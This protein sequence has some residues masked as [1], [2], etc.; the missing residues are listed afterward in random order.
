M[1]NRA[2]LASTLAVLFLALP[3]STILPNSTALDVPPP[4]LY[5]TLVATEVGAN[6]RFTPQDAQSQTI[7]VVPQVPVVLNIT[8]IF[9]DVLDHSFTIRSTD[10]AAASAY[11][12]NVDL[13]V[14]MG[15]GNSKTVEFLIVEEDRIVF[16]GRNETVET[17]GSGIRFFCVPH[18]AADMEGFIA[19]G[20]VTA[21]T[22]PP[23]KGVFLRAYWIGLLGFAGTLLLVGTSYFVIKGSSRHYRDHHEHI[24]RGGP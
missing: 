6:P 9:D 24:R 8:L 19:I 7:I 23:E 2:V 11:L 16:E 10:P 1:R 18:E 3:L 20:G 21:T 15:R 4:R 17:G 14:S 5:I 12:V 22:E 13:P